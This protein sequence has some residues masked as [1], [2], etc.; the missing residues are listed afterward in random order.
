MLVEIEL[1]QEKI[2][3]LRAEHTLAEVERECRSP[4]VVPAL[5]QAF[6]RV[7]DIG[8]VVAAASG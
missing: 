5:F 6:R 2:Q 3:R 7:L 4:F 1:Q 8:H